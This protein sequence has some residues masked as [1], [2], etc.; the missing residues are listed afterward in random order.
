MKAVLQIK[1]LFSKPE[2]LNLAE[3]LEESPLNMERIKQM[4]GVVIHVV[5]PGETLWDIAKSHITTCGAVMEL[6][7]LKEDSLK[8]GQKL[9]LVKEIGSKEKAG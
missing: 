9:L 5:Q 1:I 4:P 6:N 2:N 7:D 3:D 8:A